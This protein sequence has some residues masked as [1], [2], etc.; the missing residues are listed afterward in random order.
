[1][2]PVSPQIHIKRRDGL[3]SGEFRNR[4]RRLERPAFITRQSG[5]A[6]VARRTFGRSPWSMR[7]LHTTRNTDFR[8]AGQ[9]IRNVLK[10]SIGLPPSSGKITVPPCRSWLARLRSRRRGPGTRGLRRSIAEAL[11]TAIMHSILFDTPDLPGR[12]AGV[13]V[14][15]GTP[16]GFSG[17]EHIRNR[18]SRTKEPSMTG[19]PQTVVING[20][21]EALQAIRR[22]IDDLPNTESRLTERKNL[23]IG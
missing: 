8:F 6:V 12:E 3:D 7:S 9:R 20:T 18:I 11:T 14:F 13:L 17:V 22:R 4:A 16:A 1:M 19:T 23:E 2:S 21:Q 15:E 10:P 5:R